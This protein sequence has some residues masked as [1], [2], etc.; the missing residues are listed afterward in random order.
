MATNRF[1]NRSSIEIS[2][3]EEEP[4]Y[5]FAR[6]DNRAQRADTAGS[7]PLPVIV[8]QAHY[9]DWLDAARSATL[10]ACCYLG[11][12]PAGEMAAIPVGT[13]VNSPQNNDPV[14]LTPMHG[15]ENG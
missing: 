11:P 14:W 7:R 2:L 8:W 12:Y 6:Q 9:S 10:A 3:H 5:S 1:L 13:H 4:S 15:V